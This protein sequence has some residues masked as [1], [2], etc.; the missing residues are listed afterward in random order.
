MRVL[1][2]LA[3]LVT[4]GC[5]TGRPNS[6]PTAYE[7]V[8]P[9]ADPAVLAELPD[10][11]TI[12]VLPASFDA[13][14]EVVDSGAVENASF[15][16]AL[17]DEPTL[18]DDQPSF[19]FS[20][21]SLVQTA[22]ANNPSIAEA[23]A[24]ANEAMGVRTQVGLKANPT[25][26]YSA[27]EIGND[28]AGG[29]HSLNLSQQFVT[30]NKRA[31]NQSVINE[32]VQRLLWEVETQRAKVRTDVTQQFFAV[33]AA[34]RRSQLASDFLEVADKGVSI[35]E[36]RLDVG[37]GTR[38]DVLQAEVQRAEVAVLKRQA[39]IAARGARRQLA[40]VSGVELSTDVA[41]SGQLEDA[42]GPAEFETLYQSLVGGSPELMA[43]WSE[44]RRAKRNLV[45]QQTQPIPNV[46][47]QIG[48]G[49]DFGSD[50]TF[51]NAGLSIPLPLHNKNQGNIARANAD[52][53]RATQKV[54]R[55]Q[56]SLKNRLAQTLQAYESAGVLLDQYQSEILPK[57]TE[58]RELAE[59]AYRAGEFEFLRVLTAR[60]TYF[61]ANLRAVAAMSSAAQQRA[62][63]DGF[64][65]SGGLLDAA[66]YQ[67][68]DG[69]RDLTLS[70]Q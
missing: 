59:Q 5:A 30:A 42:I 61:E 20:L 56:L 32:D 57:A 52:Y 36:Q 6:A 43:A 22:I 47:G 50:N 70:G 28:G 25:F 1:V 3:I 34:E 19:G 21:D 33:L 51:A 65:L 46:T 23:S 62:L 69:L 31:L 16:P 68:N 18:A 39:D 10:D 45:R 17:S 7:P 49:Q 48:V 13:N 2:P 64:L 54:H 9:A 60:R 26:S 67:G 27:E 38:A 40:A 37:E 8:A 29:L 66:D 11:E 35:A 15:V 12:D 24:A 41:L 44:V 4:L 53:C 63:L 55:L 14:V 58:S